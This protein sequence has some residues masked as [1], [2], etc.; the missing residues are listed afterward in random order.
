MKEVQVCLSSTQDVQ[1]FVSTLTSLDGDFELLSGQFVLDARSLMGIF[2]FD[3]TKPLR[4]RVY[5]D[6]QLNMRAIEPFIVTGKE[7]L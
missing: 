7:I 3:L 2:G 4:L 5:Q 1:R 6:T